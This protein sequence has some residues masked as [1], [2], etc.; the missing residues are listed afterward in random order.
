[1]TKTK[2]KQRA[3]VRLQGECKRAAHSKTEGSTQ[4]RDGHAAGGARERSVS[5]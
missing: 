3:R 1:M 5:I 4:S 2:M